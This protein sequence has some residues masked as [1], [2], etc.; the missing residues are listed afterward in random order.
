MGTWEPGAGLVELSGYHSHK[1]QDIY[2]R[3][4]ALLDLPV[5]AD[6][7]GLKHMGVG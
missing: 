7:V 3:P 5:V 6:L 1:S 2:G 4:D